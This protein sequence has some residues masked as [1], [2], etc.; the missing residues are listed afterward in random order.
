MDTVTTFLKLAAAAAASLAFA[1]AAQAGCG[2]SSMYC[3][4]STGTS[5]LP[6]LS[7]Y[8]AASGASAGYSSYST[9][10]SYTASTPMLGFSGSPSSAPGLG[11]GESL[12]A[13]S[14]PVSVDAAPGARVLGCYS[15][16]RR[17]A[18]PVAST[19]YYRVVRPVIYVR[20]PVPVP[21]PYTVNVGSYGY[22]YG[23][24]S[25]ASGVAYSRY[26]GYGPQGYYGGRC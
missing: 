4:S 12:Q 25:C 7:S 9:S 10:S 17:V 2:G 8:F 26:G 6:P 18:A 5:S 16:V 1:G 14:C 11:A 19:T 21:V 3:G 15:V 20:Y 22:G 13:T 24:G 23:Y